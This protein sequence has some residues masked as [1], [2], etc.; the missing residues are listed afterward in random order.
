M[1]KQTKLLYVIAKLITKTVF[2]F[3]YN[4]DTQKDKNMRT[5]V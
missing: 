2:L 5:H 4:I 1:N 3:I